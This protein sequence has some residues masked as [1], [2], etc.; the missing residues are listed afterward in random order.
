MKKLGLWV[1]HLLAQL[2]IPF[3]YA[4][5]IFLMRVLLNYRWE[6]LKSVRR[7]LQTLVRTGEGPLMILP[8]HLTMIDSLIIIWAMTPFWKALGHPELF[9]WNTPEKKNYAHVAPVRFFTYI[10]KCIPVVRGGSAEKTKELLDKIRQL[11]SWGQTMM[12]FPEGKRSETGRVDTENF[13]YGIGQIIHDMR[14]SGIRP[15]LMLVY[16]RGRGQVTKSTAP[17]WGERFT[18]QAKLFDP[19][20]QLQ[21]LRAGRDL[22]TQIVRELASMETAYF[23]EDRT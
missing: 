12:M 13:A 11:L 6:D 18:L 8:N 5:G 20:T 23:S 1:Q 19:Q 9:P 3:T 15:R 21:G 4:V 16:L 10:G 14:Q 22:S 7:Q 2:F 17:K